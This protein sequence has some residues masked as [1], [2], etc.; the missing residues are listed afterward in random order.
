MP[1]GYTAAITETM[2]FREF[3]MKCARAFGALITMR[4]DPSDAPI[5]EEFKPDSYH[6]DAIAKAE[7]DL[8][9]LREM[10]DA[11]KERRARSAFEAKS[12]QH[13]ESLEESRATRRRYDR[14]LREVRDWTPPTPDHQG[15]KDFM[16]QQLEESIRFDCWEEGDSEWRK[17]PKYLGPGDWWAQQVDQAN[18]DVAYHTREQKAEEDRAAMRTKWVKELRGSLGAR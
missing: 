9:E 12:K 6:A 4:D 10:D 18:R 7:A 3:A 14:M 8:K 17:P 1:T 5:P 11:T 16:I 15:L 2:Q 13:V